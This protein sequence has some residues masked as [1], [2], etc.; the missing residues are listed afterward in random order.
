VEIGEELMSRLS[1][2]AAARATARTTEEAEEGL[3]AFLEKR[4]PHWP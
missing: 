2:G 4:E 1:A 3:R